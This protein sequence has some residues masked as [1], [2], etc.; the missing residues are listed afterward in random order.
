MALGTIFRMFGILWMV[1]IN[2]VFVVVVVT[3]A[4][5]SVAVAAAA[6]AA[7]NTDI[8]NM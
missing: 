7:E 4:A 8:R 1:Q 3:A 6:A 2:Q 5:A